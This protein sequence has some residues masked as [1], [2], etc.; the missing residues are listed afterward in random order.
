MLL[1]AKTNNFVILFPDDF[2]APELKKRYED[3]YNYRN[4]PYENLGDFV[5][6]SVQSVS[7]PDM[8]IKMATQT[9]KYGKQADYKGSDPVEDVITRN[10][11]VSFKLGEGML[12]YRYMHENYI[13]YLDHKNR[14]QYFGNIILGVMDNDGY[15]METTT[16]K[17]N[18]IT[19]LSGIQYSYTGIDGGFNKFDIGINFNDWYVTTY[20]DKMVNLLN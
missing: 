3:F 18:I 10:M 9:R 13:H 2:W 12:N 4:L 1:D 17:Q 7:Y 8:K 20:Y 5:F 19:S 14:Q 16:F 11:T 15:L 6:S